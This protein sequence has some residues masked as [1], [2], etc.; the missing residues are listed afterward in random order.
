MDVLI[1]QQRMPGVQ[2]TFPFGDIESLKEARFHIAFHRDP[3]HYVNR[4]GNTADLGR[5]MKVVEMGRHAVKP[6]STKE[7]FVM[8]ATSRFVKYRMPFLGDG[9]E[10]MVNGHIFFFK[11]TDLGQEEGSGKRWK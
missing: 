1:D 4:L 7:L 10:F 6:H 8:D 5:A 2:P 11:S 9:P 3:G